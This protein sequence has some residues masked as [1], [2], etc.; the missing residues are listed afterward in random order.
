MRHPKNK[1]DSPLDKLEHDALG[2]LGLRERE[3]LAKLAEREGRTELEQLK[4]LIRARAFGRL[5]DLGDDRVGSLSLE[6]ELSE[7]V[8]VKN[9]KL[10][11]EPS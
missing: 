11:R 10:E 4:W 2:F 3:M 8:Q 5:K 9:L 7:I 6:N 1:G